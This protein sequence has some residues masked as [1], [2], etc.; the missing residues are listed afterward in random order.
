MATPASEEEVNL[1]PENIALSG[2][3]LQFVFPMNGEQV[4][5]PYIL[6][7]CMPALEWSKDQ[8]KSVNF[9][10][11]VDQLLELCHAF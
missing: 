9:Q 5:V 2:L 7:D 10:F 3:D 1:L 4:V 8:N 11:Q 6:S